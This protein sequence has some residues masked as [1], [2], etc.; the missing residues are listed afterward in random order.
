MSKNHKGSLGYQM[1]KALQGVFRPGAS[2]HLAK[3]HH[4]D[5]TLI[6]SISTMRTDSADVHQFSRFI[7]ERWPEVKDLPQIKSEMAMAYIEAMVERGVSGG[8]IGRHCS[9]IRKLDAV[10]KKDGTF[11]PNAPPLLPHQADGGPGGFHSKPKPIPYSQ[12][13]TK[14]IISHV[15]TIDPEVA[16]LLSLMWK[17]GLRVTEATYLRAQDIDLENHLIN[18]NSEGNTNRTKGGRPRVVEY[19]AEFSDYFASLKNSPN[20]EPNGHLFTNRRGLPNRARQKVRRACAALNIPC[21]GTHAFRK[22]FS[23]GNYHHL[24]AQGAD[25][26]QALLATSHQLGHNRID[27]TRQSYVPKTEREKGA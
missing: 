2:R 27:V 17:A 21:L 7:R 25:D 3:K 9:T 1:M 19:Q 13:Q 8:N 18:L 6:T 4:R 23:V 16:R 15:E 14:A 22:A 11:P 5:T 24:R 10:C 20:N 26:R 12:E